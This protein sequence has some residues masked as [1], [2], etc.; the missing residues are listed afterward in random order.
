MKRIK[1]NVT[2]HF[3]DG[4]IDMMGRNVPV[5]YCARC[6]IALAMSHVLRR[7][8]IVNEFSAQIDLYDEWYRLPLKAES[9]IASFDKNPKNVKPFSF[10]L[11][12]NS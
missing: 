1:V 11:S 7:K 4:A 8:V 12:I 5:S 3:I 10:I 2:Q 6:P 9:F